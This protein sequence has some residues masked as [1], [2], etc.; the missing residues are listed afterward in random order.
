MDRIGLCSYP[1]TEKKPDYYKL[2][3][4]TSLELPLDEKDLDELYK[5]LQEME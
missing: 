5:M 3:K 1:K 4:V 2:M